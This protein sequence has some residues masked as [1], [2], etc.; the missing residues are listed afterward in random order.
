MLFSVIL[1]KD[2][3]LNLV[4]ITFTAL[5]FSELLNVYS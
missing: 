3:F 5:I 4:T 2:S 1:F